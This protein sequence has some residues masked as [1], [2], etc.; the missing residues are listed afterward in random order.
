MALTVEFKKSKKAVGWDDRFE[1]ILEPAEAQGI[2]IENVCRQGFCGACKTELLSGEVH[3]EITDG[4]DEGDMEQKMILPCVAIRIS[5]II[6][7]A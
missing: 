3:I 2:E 6:I 4:L 1:S 7:N 5:N